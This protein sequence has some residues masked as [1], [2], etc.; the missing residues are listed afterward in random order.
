MEAEDVLSHAAD[1]ADSLEPLKR[2]FRDHEAFLVELTG[3]QDGVRAVLEEGERLLDDGGL[4]KD[5][6]HE[7]KTQMSLLISRWENLKKE[8]LERQNKIYQVSCV[9]SF[10][11][12]FFRL[13]TK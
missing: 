4:Q 5:E 1:P 11:N 13:G 7:V 6:E 9:L 10:C 8:A 3:H 2:Q 12:F